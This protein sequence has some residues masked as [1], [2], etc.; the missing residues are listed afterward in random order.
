MNQ[1]FAL[2][3]ISISH[4]YD[5]LY[6]K[7]YGNQ[8]INTSLYSIDKIDNQVSIYLRQLLDKSEKEFKNYIR[9]YEI[10]SKN[11]IVNNLSYIAYFVS[12]NNISNN[13]LNNIRD[14]Y[15]KCNSLFCLYMYILLDLQNHNKIYK[16]CINNKVVIDNCYLAN[17]TF[18]L[19]KIGN[20]R[21]SKIYSS[22]FYSTLLTLTFI[23]LANVIFYRSYF[24]YITNTI[25]AMA[26]CIYDAGIIRRKIY[27]VPNTYHTIGFSVY[28]DMDKYHI[29]PNEL[30]YI[31]VNGHKFICL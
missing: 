1:N 9:D 16:I 29:K 30:C 20:F 23:F 3:A 25:M 21:D 7:L 24:I 27:I 18:N 22:N 15:S 8:N 2:V 19:K 5:E 13:L 31:Q 28:I 17:N 11:N 4:L 10:I 12:E 6:N 26:Y 14:F